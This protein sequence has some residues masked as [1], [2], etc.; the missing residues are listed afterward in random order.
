MQLQNVRIAFE[1]PNVSQSL[2]KCIND[3]ILKN[4]RLRK[5]DNR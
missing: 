1:A 2:S 3:R 5:T 4:E